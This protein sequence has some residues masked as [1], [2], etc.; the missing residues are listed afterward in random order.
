MP[1]YPPL[2]P[3]FDGV[4]DLF[5]KYPTNAFDPAK[6]T[7]LLTKKGWKKGGDGF[8][9]DAKGQRVKLPI[10]GTQIFADIGPVVAEQLKKQ[11]IDAVY[12]MPPDAGDQF[13]TGT[14]IGQ[15]NGHGG[16]IEDPYETLR[17][18]MASMVGVP[19]S[20]AVN[21]SQWYNDKYDAIVNEMAVTPLEDKAKLMDQFHRAMEI[22]LPALPDIQITEWYHRI[23]LNTMYWKNWPTKDN[24]YVNAAFW[25]L[26]FQLILNNLEPA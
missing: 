8:W 1:K 2:L 25:H 13:S 11:G 9:N 4:K 12:Q 21:R 14:Y 16:S 17:L 24:A 18:Y 19:G 6:G 20:H 22:W 5:A 7:D 26:T 10:N 23:A 3:Y 15:L